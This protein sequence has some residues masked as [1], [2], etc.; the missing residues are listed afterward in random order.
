MEYAGY[1]PVPS[2][3]WAK[4]MTDIA[5]GI[6]NVQDEREAKR[7]EL[8]KQAEDTISSINEYSSSK[9]PT[10]NDFIMTGA[11]STREYIMEQ[12]RLLKTG[13]IKP[14]EYTRRVSNT[15]DGWGRLAAVAKDFD[16]RYEETV[17]RMESGEASAM[18]AYMN[19][20]AA[21][22]MN[23]KGKSITQDPLNGRV[24]VA[25]YDNDGNKTG[26]YDVQ[27]LNAGLNQRQNKVNVISEVDNAVKGLGEVAFV[28]PRTGKYTLSPMIRG[29]YQ[30]KIKPNIAKAILS[31]KRKV[32]S[33]LADNVQ[34][35]SF[36]MD[37]ND[38]D[39]NKILL[40][41]DEN[42]IMQPQLK[43]EQEKVAKE[44]VENMIDSRVDYKQAQPEKPESK[45]SE[46][47]QWQYNELVKS[48][49]TQKRIRNLDITIAQGA[50]NSPGNMYAQIVNKRLE[51]PGYED[52]TIKS[53]TPSKNGYTTV[54]LTRASYGK[55]GEE[56]SGKDFPK[57][58]NI[59]M[60]SAA[61]KSLANELINKSPGEYQIPTS[62]LVNSGSVDYSQF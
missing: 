1:N 45:S 55:K 51:A 11:N 49:N 21:D 57:T 38:K 39:P 18:E 42:G 9:A 2:V 61:F 13:Q 47:P 46:M 5:T 25:K 20:Y 37:N 6:Q 56:D 32:A 40:V 44:Y 7:Q 15:K 28:D 19:E 33:V 41:A 31:D 27:T 52:Y 22:L 24:F 26:L 62:D 35:Y 59:T 54:V 17:S 8:D 23:L 3:N 50:K 10:F 4:A 60:T 29:S 36:T 34:G 48:Q 30:S 58:K 16:A 14:S 43:P 53:F 12:N